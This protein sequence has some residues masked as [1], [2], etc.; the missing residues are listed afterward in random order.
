MNCYVIISIL[1]YGREYWITAAEM[2]K[3]LKAREMGFTEIW[4]ANVGN[5]VVLQ[6]VGTKKDHINIR[7]RQLEI[8]GA[9]HEDGELGK[10][11][12]HRTD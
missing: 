6:K 3:T 2:K 7:K 4:S 8:S 12:N 1:L 9:P 11:N 10:S 5:D